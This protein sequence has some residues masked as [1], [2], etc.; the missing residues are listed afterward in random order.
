MQTI[1]GST[2]I[3]GY[4]LAKFLPKY[5]NNIRLVSRQPK[6]VNPGDEILSADITIPEQTFKAVEKSEVVYLTIGLKYDIDVWQKQWPVIMEN[7]INACKK[8]NS[9]LVFFDNVYLYGKVNGWMTENTPVNPVSK[10]GEVRAKLA[11]KLMDE[12]EK[13]NLKALIAR[14]ADFYGPNAVGFANALVFD[15]LKKGKKPQCLVND[16]LKHSFTFTPDAGEATAILGNTEN[17]YNQVWHLPTNSNV[18]TMK[19]FIE[20]ASKEFGV[21]P[22]YTVLKKWILQ[23]VGLF[24]GVIKESIE[25][26]YQNEYEY[27]FSSAKFEKEFNLEPTSYPEGIKTTVQSLK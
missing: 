25:M 6:K 23:L 14:A 1:L 3:I 16:K 15:N 9:K 26:L 13:G 21:G 11:R 8:Y 5:T 20:L 17:A 19:K 27:L 7:V 2:G 22:K 12:V 18:L 24:N 4:E 10:K